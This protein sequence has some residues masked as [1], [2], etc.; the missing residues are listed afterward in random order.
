MRKKLSEVEIDQILS[1]PASEMSPKEML[2]V[3]REAYN[4]ADMIDSRI[5]EDEAPPLAREIE[6]KKE[7]FTIA[8]ITTESLVGFAEEVFWEFGEYGEKKIQIVRKVLEIIP[9]LERIYGP[10]IDRRLLANLRRHGTHAIA[11]SK[12]VLRKLIKLAEKLD[13]A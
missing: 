7:L 11:H 2:I 5:M 10:T 4:I 13:A 1:K 8:R 12:V 9:I 6:M 3:L